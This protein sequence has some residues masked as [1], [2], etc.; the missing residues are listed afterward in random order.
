MFRTKNHDAN[1]INMSCFAR[2]SM[3][4]TTFGVSKIDLEAIYT[5]MVRSRYKIMDF[6]TFCDAIVIVAMKIFAQKEQNKQW[7]SQNYKVFVSNLHSFFV[8]E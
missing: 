3:L 6:K 2:M 4:L 8:K 5:N 7:T 1:T